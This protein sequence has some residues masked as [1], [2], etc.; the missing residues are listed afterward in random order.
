MN[1]FPLSNMHLLINSLFTNAAGADNGIPRIHMNYDLPQLIH[2][3]HV[4]LS[5]DQQGRSSL[6]LWC[7][8]DVAV[9]IIA[10]YLEKVKTF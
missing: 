3:L 1:L 4:T 2:S 7:V 9:K 6:C 5:S 10:Y 8:W